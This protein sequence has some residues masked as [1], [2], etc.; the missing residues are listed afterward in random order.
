MLLFDEPVNG[1]DPEGIRWVRGLLQGL[2]AEGRTVFV[3][4]HLITEMSMTAQRLVVIGRG[5]LIAETTVDEFTAQSAG[6]VVR[7]VTPNASSFVS[8]LREI[9]AKVTVDQDGAVVVDGLSSADVGRFAAHRSFTL[10]ELT[11]IRASLE[12]AF[13]ELTRDAVE[14]RADGRPIALAA[15]SGP[16]REEKS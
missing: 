13:M 5:K 6:K 10:F 7:V 16:Y 12:D 8:A 3:S 2:A 1:L 11:P 14:F 4:S 9:G 15:S